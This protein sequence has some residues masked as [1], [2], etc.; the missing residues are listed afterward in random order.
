MS[1]P[2]PIMRHRNDRRTLIL[3]YDAR[4]LPPL[5]DTR[6][7]TLPIRITRVTLTGLRPS[8]SGVPKGAGDGIWHLHEVDV[9]GLKIVGDGEPSMPGWRSFF[10]ADGRAYTLDDLPD[11]LRELAQGELEAES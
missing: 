8:R 3:D 10:G 1:R 11:W 9:S 7:D 4:A 2:E 5:E 6:Y